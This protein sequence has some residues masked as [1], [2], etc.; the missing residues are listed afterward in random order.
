MHGSALM[1]TSKPGRPQILCETYYL[2]GAGEVAV[3]KMAVMFIASD[4]FN[5]KVISGDA[6]REVEQYQQGY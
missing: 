2:I 4:T 5:E 3:F 1:P 6:P